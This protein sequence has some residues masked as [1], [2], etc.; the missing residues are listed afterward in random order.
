M[1]TTVKTTAVGGKSCVSCPSFLADAQQRKTMGSSISGPICGSKMLPL[2]AP[3][4]PRDAQ[5]RALAF[6]ANDCDKY[7]K[8]VTFQTMERDYTAQLT[9]GIDSQAMNA[10]HDDNQSNARCG[11][12]VHYVS[13]QEV[14]QEK[15]WTASICRATGSLMPDDKLPYYARGCGKFKSRIGPKSRTGNLHH[16]VF[17]GHFGPT[18]GKIDPA[19]E[20]RKAVSKSADPAAHPTDREVTEAHKARGIISWRKIT[21]P[22]GYGAPTFLPIYDVNSYSEELRVLVPNTNDDEHP[23]LY[24]DHNGFVYTMA[25]LWRELDEAPAWWGQGG[26]GKTEF[27][28]YLAWLMRSPFH[29]ISITAASELDDIIGKMRFENN[30]TI[31]QYGRLPKA[32]NSPGVILVD[33]PNTGPNEL[34]QAIRPLT[35][36]SKTLVVDQNRHERIPR[37][38]DTYLALAMN[39]NWDPR[40]VGTNTLGDA[41]NSRLMHMFFGLPPADLEVEIIQKRVGLD[42]WQLNATQAKALMGVANDLR[43]QGDA[44][45][46]TWGIRHQIKAARA[47]KWFAP[48]VAYRRAVGDSLEPGQLELILTSVNSHFPER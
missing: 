4:Q 8:E 24:A 42:G 31:F 35:D 47:L 13:S 46:T 34:W 23:E 44:L 19:A 14:Q 17:F 9:V 5:S 1:T 12:C 40:N 27:A 7:G 48:S 28:R 32:W 21:D 25:V 45:H 3:N 2:I 37:G 30:E 39:P 26:V 10:T 16:F 38:K 43:G 11:D 6:S 22:E 36:N 33:E 29:R 18:F 41:D 15:G 20:Y